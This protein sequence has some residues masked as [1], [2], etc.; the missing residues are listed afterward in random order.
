M[1][2]PIQTI[3]EIQS[4]FSEDLAKAFKEEELESIRVAYLGRKGK[5]RQLFDLLATL[6]PQEKKQFGGAINQLKNDLQEKFDQH[7]AQIASKSEKIK[8]QKDFYD[9][10]LMGKPFAIGHQHPL[11]LIGQQLYSIFRNLNFTVM[12]GSEIEDDYHNFEALNIPKWHPARKMQDSF[13]ITENL[14][15]RTHTS[16]VQIRSME[17]MKPP[18]RIVSIN[19]RCYRRDASDATHYPVFHQIE[20]LYVDKGLSMADLSGL[21]VEMM[22]GVFEK[23]VEI[24]FLPSYF[25]FVEPGAETLISCPFCKKKGCSVCQRSGWIELGGSGMVH[26]QV[27]RNVNID[28][29]VYS[30]FAFGWGVDR[31]AML[32]Y[33]VEDIRMLMDNHIHFLEQF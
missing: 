23:E 33:G 28:P 32:K 22:Y 6:D 10:T 26:P 8:D 19:G 15:L 1:S 27:L 12:D 7:L 9:Y 4:A 16:N 2:N 29:E 24:K 5:I 13:Y 21:L 30:G 18:L 11:S 3:Q 14:L 17:K 20:G 25:P 31:L